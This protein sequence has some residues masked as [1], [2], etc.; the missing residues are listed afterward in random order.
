MPKMG[1]LALSIRRALATAASDATEATLSPAAGDE[2]GVDKGQ[3][4]AARL[5]TL[6]EGAESAAGKV[7]LFLP[8][9]AALLATGRA[10]EVPFLA[11]STGSVAW[12]C[13]EG[14][15]C[16]PPTDTGEHSCSPGP[17]GLEAFMYV[18]TGL[19][20]AALHCSRPPA[21]TTATGAG[22]GALLDTGG[23]GA[24]V[25]LGV[26]LVSVWQFRQVGRAD[27]KWPLHPRS[28]TATR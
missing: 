10:E 28:T 1:A 4:N 5:G 19:P 17:W 18:V 25:G 2:S 22:G 15:R 21:A 20:P 7:S 27:T 9:A 8:C 3:L 24:A 14:P 13:W 6:V 16:V 12:P 26:A 23:N 11:S